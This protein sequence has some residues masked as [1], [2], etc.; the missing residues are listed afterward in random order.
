VNSPR[1]QAGDSGECPGVD[2]SSNPLHQHPDGAWWWY[3][4]TWTEERGPFATQDEAE[5]ALG[6]YCR[7]VLDAKSEQG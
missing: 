1:W 2:G 7:E 3:D 4:E 6:D 5:T